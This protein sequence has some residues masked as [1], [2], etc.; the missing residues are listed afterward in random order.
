M[1]EGL[2]KGLITNSEAIT[3]DLE[4]VDTVAIE[5]ITQLWKGML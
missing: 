3:D 4:R 2:P 1:T 5:D